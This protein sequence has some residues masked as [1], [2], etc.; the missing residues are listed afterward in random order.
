MNAGAGVN[1]SWD[2]WWDGIWLYCCIFL[3]SLPVAV[4]VVFLLRFAEVNQAQALSIAL[5]VAY[6]VLAGP[7]LLSR[8]FRSLD[9]PRPKTSTVPD[10]DSEMIAESQYTMHCPGCGARVNPLTREGLHSPEREPWR[11]ICDRCQET[12]QPEV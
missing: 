5:A 12:I 3:C 8:V 6:A 1:P 11:L 9:G 4:P 10:H 7:F 2:D